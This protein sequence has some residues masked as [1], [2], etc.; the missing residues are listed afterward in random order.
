MAPIALCLALSIR[1]T[2]WGNSPVMDWHP[3]QG[4]T[5]YVKLLETTEIGDNP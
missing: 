1:G 5:L 4:A 3:D 2:D